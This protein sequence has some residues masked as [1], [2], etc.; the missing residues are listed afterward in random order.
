M[1]VYTCSTYSPY[2]STGTLGTTVEGVARVEVIG[3]LWTPSIPQA[4]ESAFCSTDMTKKFRVV[5]ALFM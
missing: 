1:Y 3:E 2:I 4:S 5:L